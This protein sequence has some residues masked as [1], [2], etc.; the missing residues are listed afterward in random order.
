MNSVEQAFDI[1]QQ[2]KDIMAVG[3]SNLRKWN[4]NNKDLLAKIK[5]SEKVNDRV[6]PPGESQVEED[7]QSFGKFSTGLPTNDN[8]IL[9]LYWDTE[10]DS[11]YVSLQGLD[12]FAKLL[13]PT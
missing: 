13:T 11:M 8:K 9:G 4:S 1:Y 7:D 2:C 12:A 3:G 10:R 6:S 5:V